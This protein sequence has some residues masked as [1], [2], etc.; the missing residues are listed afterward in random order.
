[1]IFVGD[2]AKLNYFEKKKLS[3]R[4]NFFHFIFFICAVTFGISFTGYSQIDTRANTTPTYVELITEYKRLDSLHAEIELY[5]IGKSDTKFPIY[6]CILNGA[7]NQ[8][9][10]FQKAKNSTTI[11]INNAIHPGEPDGVNAS[12][13]LIYE[14]IR[15]GKETENMPVIAIIPAY[16]VGGMLT[17]SA[18]SRANQN[19]PEE[20]GFRGNSQNL[21][22]NRDFIKMDSENAWTF[23]QIINIL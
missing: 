5:E 1:L 20:Y 18:S 6:L 22:L 8:S 15:K 21:D 10:T 12:L 2:A 16:N 23:V 11:L 17:R 3:S 13:E 7:Q 19:G 4:M 14:W 9:K